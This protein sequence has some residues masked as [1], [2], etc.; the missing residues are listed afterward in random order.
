MAYSSKCVATIVE[1]KFRLGTY[2]C[3]YPLG[4]AK[5]FPTNLASKDF[6]FA[7]FLVCKNSYMLLISMLLGYKQANCVNISYMNSIIHAKNHAR[8]NLW[9][10]PI[11]LLVLS[12]YNV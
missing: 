4:F 11:C 10:Q 1:Y 5:V 3:I 2:S 9:W 7:W 12:L 6:F 8:K